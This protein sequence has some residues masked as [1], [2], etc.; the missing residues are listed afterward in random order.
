VIKIE[1]KSLFSHTDHSSGF[2][3]F[4]LIGTRFSSGGGGGHY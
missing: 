4:E 3:D 2:Q 1:L